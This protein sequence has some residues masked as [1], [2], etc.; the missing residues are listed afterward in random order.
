MR[1]ISWRK[2]IERRRADPPSKLLLHA[3][4]FNFGKDAA[5]D[6]GAG[7]LV[8]TKLLLNEGFQRVDAVDTD[9]ASV[10]IAQAITDSRLTFQDKSITEIPLTK[11][12]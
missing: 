9:G 11:D 7:S 10:E 1:N 8:D 5:L 12:Y 4:S 3:L 2:Y 6:I